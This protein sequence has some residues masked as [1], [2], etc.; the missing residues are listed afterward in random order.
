MVKLVFAIRRRPDLTLEAFQ[1]YWREQHA[2]LVQEHAAALHL[3]RYVQTHALDT[4]VDD[5]LAASRGSEPRV[6]DGFAELWWDSFDDLVAASSTP[7]GL[8][9]AAA[10]LEDERRF[11]DLPNSPLRLCEEHAIVG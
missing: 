6:Y 8:V 10:L 9:A 11:I 4:D 1:H 5:A 7:E 2:S 3:R